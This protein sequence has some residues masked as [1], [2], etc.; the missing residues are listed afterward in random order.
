MNKDIEQDNNVK[1][2]PCIGIDNKQHVCESNSEICV[3]GTKV[4]R[5]KMLKRDHLLFSCYECTY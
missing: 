3:C 2:I 5:K 1:F 4:R